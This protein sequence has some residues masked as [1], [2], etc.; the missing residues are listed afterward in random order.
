MT[1]TVHMFTLGVEVLCQTLVDCF[2][3]MNADMIFRM[4]F[5]LEMSCL[6]EIDT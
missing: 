6:A 1:L 5:T 3:T 4:H 2:H